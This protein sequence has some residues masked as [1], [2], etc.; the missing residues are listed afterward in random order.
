MKIA[1]LSK[2]NF[3]GKNSASHP[4]T[5]IFTNNTLFR[6]HDFTKLQVII[7]IIVHVICICQITIKS[8][9]DWNLILCRHKHLKIYLN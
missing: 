8:E 5:S 6:K 7:V 4:I 3:K 2:R 1:S 9:F